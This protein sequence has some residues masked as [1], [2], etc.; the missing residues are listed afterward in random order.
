MTFNKP[1]FYAE[2]VEELDDD[3]DCPMELLIGGYPALLKAHCELCDKVAL[4]E[5]RL[6]SLLS[7]VDKNT[8]EILSDPD[9][10]T[11]ALNYDIRVWSTDDTC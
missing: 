2:Y 6:E 4:L 9:E 3:Y 10:T 7:A 1:I 5:R 8:I 11:S